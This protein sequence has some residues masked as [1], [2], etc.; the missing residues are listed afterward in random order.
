MDREKIQSD[1]VLSAGRSVIRGN[2]YNVFL[3]AI[4]KDIDIV[5][6]GIVVV[7]LQQAPP[8]IHVRLSDE[9]F[10]GF[11]ESTGGEFKDGREKTATY[12]SK[13]LLPTCYVTS[14]KSFG[15]GYVLDCLQPLP[16]ACMPPGTNC[17]W[18]EIQAQAKRLKDETVEECKRDPEFKKT[19]L[20]KLQSSSITE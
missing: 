15:A 11:N 13:G 8:R 20:E 3:Q 10:S 17:T 14:G 2:L 6:E 1:N 7:N 19:T 18:S 9:F 16:L 4:L 5:N 12:R